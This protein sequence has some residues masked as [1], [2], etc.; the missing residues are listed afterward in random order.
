ME[1]A[2]GTF[3]RSFG[4]VHVNLGEGRAR[5]AELKAFRTGRSGLNK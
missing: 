3:S 1:S 4:V 2:P 5:G